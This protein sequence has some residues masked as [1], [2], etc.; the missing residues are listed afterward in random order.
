MRG[1]STGSPHRAVDE[2]HPS[3]VAGRRKNRFAGLDESRI[4]CRIRAPSP[5]G[6]QERRG[7]DGRRRMPLAAKR[8]NRFE[9]LTN[10]KLVVGFAPLRCTARKSGTAKTAGRP[11]PPAAKQP[12]R[13]AGL[14]RSEVGCKMR[15][16][17]R[18]PVLRNKRRSRRATRSRPARSKKSCFGVLTETKHDVRYAAPSDETSLGADREAGNRKPLILDS[19]RR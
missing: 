14:D 9:R 10:R 8:K 16:P 17:L 7:E 12:D 13:F 3:G 15:G 18:R 4:G 2:G 1:P 19:V 5:N 6:S 11:R